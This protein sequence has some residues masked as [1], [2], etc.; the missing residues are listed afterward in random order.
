[1]LSFPVMNRKRFDQW[2]LW[3]NFFVHSF[4]ICKENFLFFFLSKWTMTSSLHPVIYTL[5]SKEKFCT[6]VFLKRVAAR[7][8]KHARKNQGHTCVYANQVNVNH[9]L[10]LWRWRVTKRSWFSYKNFI[11]LDTGG[12]YLTK[13]KIWTLVLFA[14]IFIFKSSKFG[15]FM[16]DPV[17]IGPH[18]PNS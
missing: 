14:Y 12:E 11:S 1:M 2:R 8:I 3:H 18:C 15:D 10:L 16:R 5:T 17:T 7:Y 9:E 13:K 6:H 4:T